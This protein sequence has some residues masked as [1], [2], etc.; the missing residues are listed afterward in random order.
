MNVQ[1]QLWQASPSTR[2]GED[3][4]YGEAAS[5]HNESLS[6]HRRANWIAGFSGEFARNAIAQ[7]L[8]PGIPSIELNGADYVFPGHFAS[9]LTTLVEANW[10]RLN[11]IGFEIN[12]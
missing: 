4:S 8:P 2:S 12:S 9:V 6:M 5:S 11:S 10:L 7:F 1:A 3:G